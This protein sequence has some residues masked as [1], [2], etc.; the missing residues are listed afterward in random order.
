MLSKESIKGH[1]F[2]SSARR[3]IKIHLVHHLVE[4][5]NTSGYENQGGCGAEEMLVKMFVKKVRNEERKFIGKKVGKVGMK[6]Q[7]RLYKKRK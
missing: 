7:T 5:A 3:I 1:L 6:G 2:L 4:S